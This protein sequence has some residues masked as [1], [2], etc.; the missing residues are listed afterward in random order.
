[1]ATIIFINL[2]DKS[3][4]RKYICEKKDNWSHHSQK[5]NLGEI[6]SLI[7]NKK[8]LFAC[9]AVVGLPFFRHR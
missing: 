7:L 5:L 6:Q 9:N 1:M 3:L 2:N 4:L 8:K